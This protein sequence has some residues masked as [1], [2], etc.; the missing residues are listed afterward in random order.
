VAVLSSPLVVTLPPAVVALVPAVVA[1]VPAVVA[2]VP[3][4]FPSPSSSLQATSDKV[5]ASTRTAQ[6]R[7]LVTD[8]RLNSHSVPE[9]E[10]LP[11]SRQVAPSSSDRPPSR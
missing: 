8:S 1:L 10:M 2:L 4:P 3:G 11:A 6:R 5:T 7:S 9:D